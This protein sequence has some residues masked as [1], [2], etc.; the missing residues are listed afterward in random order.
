[1]PLHDPVAEGCLGA[2]GHRARGTGF[3]TLIVLEESLGLR[4]VEPTQL[5][6]RGTLS[7]RTHLGSAAFVNRV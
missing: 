3:Q 1:M 4:R 6:A 7:W 5:I 2:A